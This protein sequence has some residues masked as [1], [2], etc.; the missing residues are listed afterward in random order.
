MRLNQYDGASDSKMKNLVMWSKM[1]RLGPT[2]MVSTG[3][4]WRRPQSWCQEGA[5]RFGP[6]ETNYSISD[7]DWLRG[8]LI[9]L[10]AMQMQKVRLIAQNFLTVKMAGRSFGRKQNYGL[11]VTMFSEEWWCIGRAL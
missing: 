4:K 5:S 6:V 3:T 9:I 11:T 8:V 2:M 1:V 10:R 7:D